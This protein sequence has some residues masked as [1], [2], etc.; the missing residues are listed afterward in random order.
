MAGKQLE[1]DQS[2]TRKYEVGVSKGVL[3]P[4][5]AGVYQKGVAWN[6]L[7]GVTQSPGGAD[8]T[9]F[10]AD[11]IKYASV[12]AAETFGATI[13]AMTYPDEFAPCDGSV[14]PYPGMRFGQQSR[15][16]FG[17]SY[18]NKVGTDVDPDAG[19]VIHVIYNMTAAPSERAHET[20]NESPAA[21]PLSWEAQSTPVA[22][23]GYKASSHFEFNSLTS[24]VAQMKALEDMIYGTELLD[25]KM[26]TPAELLALWAPAEG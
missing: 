23:P 9:D 2:G 16:A 3:F 18:Q 19:Y 14:E 6:G 5:L 24:T 15:Q 7:T 11:N 17:F 20:V 13:E 4:L 8:L 12:R 25:P 1:W 10:W 22:V 21:A 26:P